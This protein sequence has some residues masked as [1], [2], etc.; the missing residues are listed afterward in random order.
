METLLHFFP[1]IQIQIFKFKLIKNRNGNVLDNSNHEFT[2]LL[3]AQLHVKHCG[4]LVKIPGGRRGRVRERVHTTKVS[5][6][7]NCIG[8]RT[9]SKMGEI[10]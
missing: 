1:L 6:S 5:F 10:F 4:A 7:F 8:V 2:V 3:R 9:L